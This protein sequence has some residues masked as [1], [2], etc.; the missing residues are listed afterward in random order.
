VLTR[1]LQ[2]AWPDARFFGVQVGHCPP[3]TKATIITCD[4][5]FERDARFPPPFPSC[6]NYDAKVWQHMKRDAS[7]GAL[8]WNVSA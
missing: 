5:P 1:A 6:S 4:E 7:P 8:F 2:L 3:V